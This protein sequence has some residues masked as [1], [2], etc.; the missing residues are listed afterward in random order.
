MNPDSHTPCVSLTVMLSFPETLFLS[1]FV[2]LF[3]TDHLRF[4]LGSFL[5]LPTLGE[6]LYIGLEA[7]VYALTV[8][9]TT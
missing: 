8:K 7:Q 1:F 5:W 2:S 6:K 3:H 4:G 9:L